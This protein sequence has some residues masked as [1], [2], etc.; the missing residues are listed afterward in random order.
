VVLTL[1]SQVRREIAGPLKGRGSRQK[2]RQPSRQ[3]ISSELDF[4]LLSADSFDQSF[5][6][7]PDAESI[8]RLSGA[9]SMLMQLRPPDPDAPLELNPLGEPIL[10]PE[11]RYSEDFMNLL[12]AATPREVYSDAPTEP[13]EAEQSNV[14]K[15][16]K[17]HKKD[18][19]PP[20]GPH[21]PVPSEWWDWDM[22]GGG[23]GGRWADDEVAKINYIP[24]PNKITAGDTALA[25]EGE[26]PAA[27][28][29][30]DAELL[31]MLAAAR[32]GTPVISNAAAGRSSR[33]HR[34]RL[35]ELSR[36][37]HSCAHGNDE[38]SESLAM[39]SISKGQ[40]NTNLPVGG[41]RRRHVGS[42]H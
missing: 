9:S 37:N 1:R 23:V 32:G 18:M 20:R 29:G 31:E 40:R 6:S 4:S 33:A 15:L 8:S 7:V 16:P 42:S 25:P 39:P 3:S 22:P 2:R 41:C 14:V 21:L 27:D 38:G 19:G 28:G 24:P 26:T 12:F 35:S 5:M 34:Q 13:E 17:A 30:L 36:L 10:P 11:P